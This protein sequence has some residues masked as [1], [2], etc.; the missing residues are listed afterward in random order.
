[1]LIDQPSPYARPLPEVLQLGWD[2]F[3]FTISPANRAALGRP[4]AW[5]VIAYLAADC[6][7]D[8]YL[9]DLMS[10]DL[11]ELQSVGSSDAVHVLALFDGPLLADSF[12][13]RLNAGARLGEDLVMRFNELN[14]NRA[15]TLTMAIHLAEAYPARHRLLVL[16][17]HGRGWRGVA[18]DQNVGLQYRREPGKLVLPGSGTECDARLRAC[19]EVAQDL[20]NAA[21]ERPDATPQP[22]D[23]LAFDACHMGQIEAIA[24]LADHART[25]VVCEDAMPGEG[26]NYGAVLR[27]LHRQPTLSPD[28]LARRLVQETDL[29]YASPSRHAGAPALAALDTV[30]LTPL[31]EA[32]V[33]LAGALDLRDARVSAATEHALGTAWRE[34]DM[35]AIDLPGFA[36]RLL[37]CQLPAD[38][39]AAARRLL[40][41]WDAARLAGP[42]QRVGARCGPG[43]AH[44]LAVYAPSPQAFEEAYLEQANSLPHGLA[45]WAW[46]LG[47]LYARQLGRT[48]PEHPLVR[49]IV[50][51]LRAQGVELPPS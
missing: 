43:D 45:R 51:T 22:L 31:A 5:T 3:E 17:G 40:S 26:L 32:L 14:T 42:Q 35:G 12:I 28:E 21:I 48:A 13:A 47:T 49:A 2:D 37:E 8:D 23:V 25:F 18:L 50:R 19:Q 27:A 39:A 1:M 29:F 41:A 34:P 33:A 44:G 24:G 11:R 16:G 30:A 6:A 36:L 10:D 38:A 4:A 15:E 9:A 7:G 20:L 46:W